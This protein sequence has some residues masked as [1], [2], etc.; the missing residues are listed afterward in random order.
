MLIPE[1]QYCEFFIKAFQ[2]HN[3]Q[4]CALLVDS[5]GGYLQDWLHS[6]LRLPAAAKMPQGNSRD[7]S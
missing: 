5:Q 6:D 3:I 7:L 1:A 2:R 4:T